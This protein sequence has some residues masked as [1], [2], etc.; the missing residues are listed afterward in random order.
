M[1]HKFSDKIVSL[2]RGKIKAF[3]DSDMKNSNKAA[4]VQAKSELS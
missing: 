1:L 3:G 2:G 4:T